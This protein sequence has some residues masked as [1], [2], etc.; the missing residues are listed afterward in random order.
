MCNLEYIPE[1]LC[2]NGKNIISQ[3]E[4][5]EKLYFRCKSHQ[6]IYPYN[7]LSLA[8]LSHNRNFCDETTYTLNDVLWNISE[9]DDYQFYEE[10]KVAELEISDVN[11][12]T[13]D[14]TLVSEINSEL[15]LRIVLKHT[16]LECM[17]PHSE[18]KFYL[19]DQEVTMT[20]YK[21]T[22]GVK[23]G[24]NKKAIREL[25]NDARIELTSMLA[26]GFI[27]SN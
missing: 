23:K 2:R 18:F 4:I 21:E 14:K 25:R 16:P 26:T 1:H 11:G 5:G 9:D 6:L 8:T 10:F 17:F 13:F 15:S 7:S 3:F 20:N 12:I 24:P 19:T 22:L 27:S